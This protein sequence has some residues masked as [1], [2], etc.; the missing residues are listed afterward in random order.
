MINL[1]DEGFLA[2][3][4]HKIQ[5]LFV[6]LPSPSASRYKLFQLYLS[7]FNKGQISPPIDA[8]KVMVSA[9]GD[10]DTRIINQ[11]YK[12]LERL[13]LT[14]LSLVSSYCQSQDALKEMYQWQR[15]IGLEPSGFRRFKNNQGEFLETQVCV[16]DDILRLI[17]HQSKSEYKQT[18][19]KMQQNILTKQQSDDEL[20]FEIE[21][22]LALNFYS[23]NEQIANFAKTKEEVIYHAVTQ[24]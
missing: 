14:R 8:I 20:V 23:N 19:H 4:N 16:F 5:K 22:L 17:E 7:M 6:M 2:K 15:Q 18:V 3:L 11:A 10:F 9:L 13:V 24:D 21:V 12:A 1:T